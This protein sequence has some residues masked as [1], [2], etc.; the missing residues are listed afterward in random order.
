MQ[1]FPC[2]NNSLDVSF[3][4]LWI[5]YLLGFVENFSCCKKIITDKLWN[6]TVIIKIGF[7]FIISMTVSI[8]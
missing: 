1:I 3:I 8:D 2:M 5:M 6:K 7:Y 4:F